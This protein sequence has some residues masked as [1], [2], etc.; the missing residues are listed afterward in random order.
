MGRRRVVDRL[1]DAVFDAFGS[2]L[3]D[4][5]FVVK[6][7][8][9]HRAE[10]LDGAMAGGNITASTPPFPMPD[11]KALELALHAYA[12]TL[13]HFISEVVD[14]PW[15]QRGAKTR[16]SVTDGI[17]IWFGPKSRQQAVLALPVI[18]WDGAVFDTELAPAAGTDPVLRFAGVLSDEHLAE[19]TRRY[20]E[21]RQETR[22]RQQAANAA[23]A[24]A[25]ARA[26]G[27]SSEQMRS[28]VHEEFTVRGQELPAG[29]EEFVAGILAAPHNPHPGANSAKPMGKAAIQAA[30]WLRAHSADSGTPGKE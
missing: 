3:P 23:L 9:Y 18:A 11:D 10:S 15:P 30:R 2:V 8:L 4:G 13:R 5:V 1:L 7:G 6:E 25:Q 27:L 19:Q 12:E 22:A 21:S 17:W 16:V 24:A 14:A 28:V 29:A 26:P 20:E